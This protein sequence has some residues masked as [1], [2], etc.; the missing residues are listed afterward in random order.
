MLGKIQMAETKNSFNVVAI[1]HSLI[2]TLLLAAL[3]ALG[4]YVNVNKF[5]VDDV[6]TNGYRIVNFDATS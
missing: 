4:V 6:A 5:I 2:S 1:S 3:V